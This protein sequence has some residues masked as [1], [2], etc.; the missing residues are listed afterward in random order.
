VRIALVSPRYRPFVGGVETHVEQLAR[1]FAAAGHSVQVLTHRH[2]PALSP[3]EEYAGVL[4][5]RF[6]VPVPSRHF[7]VAP[8]LHRFLRRHGPDFDVVHAHSYHNTAAL[9][10][11]LAGPRP[12]VFTP[13]Y[14][15]TGHSP[16]RS[17][18]HIPYRTVGARMV[19]GADAVICVSR[20]EAALVRRHFGVAGH[21]LRVIPN[22][23]DV[24]PLHAARPFT[25]HG[26]VV[27][28]VGRLEGYKR[29]DLTLRAMD[30]LADT[31]RLRV[32]GDGP[33]LRSLETLARRLRHPDR[34]AFLGN[35]TAADLRRWYRTAAVYV[36]MSRHEAQS[37]TTLEAAAAGAA[38]V[39]SDI[40]AHRDIAETIVSGMTLVPLSAGPVEV[41]AA[42]RAAGGRPPVPARVPSWDEVAAATLGVYAE[43]ARRPDRAGNP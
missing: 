14:H 15:G 42:I 2:D 22:G 37:I 29:V 36:S 27:L 38:I 33:G 5:R 17:L 26:P 39:A 12:F 32:I 23:V 16:F 11:F 35:V 10:A 18:L 28:T 7:A 24:D 41:A 1:R 21:R 8:Q 13:H 20:P 34:V 3:V 4:V 6:P 40:P 43:V 31:Y 25:E 19:R 30:E 9:S